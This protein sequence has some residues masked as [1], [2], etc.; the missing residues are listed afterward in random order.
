MW[1]SIEKSLSNKLGEN[2]KIVSQQPLTGGDIN[3]AYKIDNGEIPFFVKVNDKTH[4]SHFG[5]EV[6]SLEKI[7]E[8]SEIDSPNVITYG[9][10][11]DCSYLVLDYIPF[12]IQ[13]S[14]DWYKL[15]EQ[16]ALLHKNSEHGQ[17]G[18]DHDNYIGHT[19]QVNPWSSNWKRFFSEQRIGWQL[20]LLH[21]KGI[22]IGDID[23]IVQECHDGLNHHSPKPR[24]VHGDL[25]SGNLA[26]FE[27]TPLIYDP[28]CYYGDREVDIAMT[29][30]FGRLPA[31]FY[32]GY[33]SIQP[34]DRGYDKR[35]NIYNF[36]HVLNHANMFG[37][38]YVE[39]SQAMINRIISQNKH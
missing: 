35:K 38:V 27:D 19:R 23:H 18:W 3:R 33:Q 8:F 37:G 12:D 5:C 34:L 25:W 7:Q 10:S 28:A 30:L 4:I 26:F 32:S 15:G 17:F 39:Q 1:E 14:N 16:L 6:Y 11:D 20:Q 29:E 22:H 21:E 24:L 2:Y 36:Y 31:D 13:A 9:A